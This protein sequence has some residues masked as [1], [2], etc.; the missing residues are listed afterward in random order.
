M[1]FSISLDPIM[2]LNWLRKRFIG[3]QLQRVS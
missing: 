1:A 2:P 3:E